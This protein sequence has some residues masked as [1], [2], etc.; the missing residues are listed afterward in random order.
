[1][2]N[3][4]ALDLD[5]LSHTY[6]RRTLRG[7]RSVD[8]LRGVDLTV[9]RGELVGLLGPNGSGKSTLLR[10]CAGLLRPTGGTARALGEDPSVPRSAIRG[11]IGWVVRDDRSFN[12]RLSGRQN[13][14]LYALLEHVDGPAQRIDD[15]L[16][17]ARLLDVADRPY[18]FY[19]S[20]MKQ[21][22][23]FA[24]ALLTDPPL[25]LMDEASSGL[26][27]GLRDR[28]HAAVRERVD[29]GAGV[30]FASHDLDEIEALCDRVA[31]LVDGRIVRQGL[32]DDVADEA[33][34][35]F[36]ERAEATR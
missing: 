31:L 32:W 33:R 6:T 23:C 36:A 29:A 3:D 22:L 14:M 19:S 28:F 20:G 1:M 17:A 34:R 26:D 24:R 30:L 18:R 5:G 7:R 15:A 16:A 13:L 27:P 25:L 12:L 35:V 9:A 10:C 8:A 2:S 4:I 21:R 11:R